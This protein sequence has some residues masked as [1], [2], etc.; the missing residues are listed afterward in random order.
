MSGQHPSVDSV[1]NGE[2]QGEYEL[3]FWGSIG[4]EYRRYH[5]TLEGAKS[6]ALMRLGDLDNRRAHPAIIYG[7]DLPSD[8]VTIP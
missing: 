1:A 4:D 3:T 5:R 2:A 7:P 6:E 8:G